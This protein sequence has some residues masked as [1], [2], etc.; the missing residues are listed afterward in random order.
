[1]KVMYSLILL[2]F[3]LGGN[4]FLKAEQCSGKVNI[5]YIGNSIT[6]ARNQDP[7]PP[8]AAA[9]YLMAQGYIVEYANCGIS[10]YTTGYFKP[11]GGTYNKVI[12]AADG[13]KDKDALLVFSIKLGTN[14]SSIN[15]AVSAEEYKQNLKTMAD[16]LFQRYPGCKIILNYPIWYSPDTQNAGAAYL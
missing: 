8:K 6:E 7:T 9:E 10:G 15:L 14:D 2:L 5:V 16:S 11:P 12:E 13:F 1:M 4:T 3:S